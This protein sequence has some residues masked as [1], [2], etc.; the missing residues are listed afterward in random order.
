MSSLTP[1]AQRSGESPWQRLIDALPQGAAQPEEVWRKR[2]HGILALLVVH[3]F[4]LFAFGVIRGQSPGHALLEASVPLVAV[5][6][7]SQVSTRRMKGLVASF[8]LIASSSILVHFSGGSI[9]AHFHFFVVLPIIALYQDWTPFLVAIGYVVVHHGAMGVLA[10][11]SVFN[12]PAAINRP[13]LWAGIHGLFVLA[14]SA[15]VIVAW[16]LS[17]ESQLKAAAYS[18]RLIEQ[19]A[20]ALEQ[21]RSA[22]AALKEAEQRYRRVIETAVQGVFQTTPE[23][24]LEVANQALAEVLGYDSP[25]Q[26]RA[27]ITDVT[28]LYT[29]PVRRDTLLARLGTDGE[30]RA[31]E[32]EAIRRDSRRIWVSMSARADRA[33]DGSIL[34]VHGMLTDVTDRKAAELE[35]SLLAAIVNSHSDGIW[36]ASLDQIVTSWNPGAEHMFG[37]TAEEMKGEHL[38]VLLPDDPDDMGYVLEDLARGE[39]RENL[40]RVRR[41]KSGELIDVALTLAPI[42]DRVGQVTGFSTVCRDIRHRK[43]NEMQ[44]A[45]LEDRVRQSQK[46]EAVGQLAGG[47]AHDFNNLLSVILNFTGFV[48]DQ[49][50]PGDQRREDLEEVI[51]AAERGS[52]LTRQL[53]TFARKDVARVSRVSLNDVIAGMRELFRRTLQESIDITISTDPDLRPV[54]IDVSRIEQILMNLAVNARDAM[55]KGG[56]FEIVTENVTVTPD[57]MELHPGLRQRDYVKLTVGDTGTGM[58]RHVQD[59]VF[60]PFFTT[61]EVGEGTGLGLATTYAIVTEAGGDIAL[62][63]EPG[64][65]TT[66]AIYLPAAEAGPAELRLPDRESPSGGTGE[67]VL[68]VEDSQ[69]V[70]RLAE[71]ILSRNGYVVLTAVSGDEALRKAEETSVDVVLS[72]VVMPG[73][74]VQELG[75]QLGKPMVFMSGYTDRIIAQHG[76]IDG[77]GEFLQKPFTADQLL[78]AVHRALHPSGRATLAAPD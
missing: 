26:L 40:E 10:P 56:R 38:S 49:L 2:H 44:R 66:F 14:E 3:A 46:M 8:G 34:R 54:E 22:E 12:H 42:F 76:L 36:S 25:E 63:S 35:Q 74:S 68:V 51:R 32:A 57:V 13:W 67:T 70:R 60:E 29:D 28:Q 1:T 71:R 37:Y 41:T 7:A 73:M 5:F 50:P 19:Q 47:V 43:N 33:A 45:L 30:V 6:V 31:F 21:H 77:E 59:R 23:G 20:H 16:R 27:E 58:P 48:T 15:A 72:D 78:I 53:L 52:N 61:K 62:Y 75:S 9:E 69:P 55:A 65:G 18:E 4:G 11:E 24:R 17:E 39:S 64:K